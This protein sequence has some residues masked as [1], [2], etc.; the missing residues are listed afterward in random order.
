MLRS[1][2]S[3]FALIELLLAMA[4]LGIL[5]G[6]SM[7]ALSPTRNIESAN[8]Q[9]IQVEINQLEARVRDWQIAGGQLTGLT[10]QWKPICRY[11][12]VPGVNDPKCVAFD[13]VQDDGYVK[14]IP[15]RSPPFASPYTGYET[16]TQDG[17]V[18][19]RAMFWPR[20]LPGLVLWFDAEDPNVIASGVRAPDCLADCIISW[21]DKSGGSP[22]I[23]TTSTPR[24]APLNG[25]S[26]NGVNAISFFETGFNAAHW[27]VLTLVPSCPN[28]PARLDLRGGRDEMEVFI[29]SEPQT[30]NESAIVFGKS[31]GNGVQY[32]FL[33]NNG[34]ASARV[35]NGTTVTDTSSVADGKPH[36]FTWSVGLTDIDIWQD[37][38]LTA[39]AANVVGS[40][41]T[42]GL[43]ILLG[44]RRGN[45]CPFPTNGSS[46][47]EYFYGDLGEVIVYNR[48]L[49]EAEREA[50]HED[51]LEK[52]KIE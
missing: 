16:K 25:G 7:T 8:E 24:R 48:K 14:L 29:V 43:E 27:D 47:A 11:K 20:Q 4:L 1:Y 38:N 17:I 50:V 36:I 40:Y 35:G 9:K 26:I 10:D 19:V 21:K 34:R 46:S 30:I 23:T 18:E 49:T 15:F 22:V 39:Q 28:P 31:W 32:Q 33:L 3:G 13:E 45:K 51:L 44:T 41:F 12:E 52:W 6:V 2:R 5:I 37:R 42:T